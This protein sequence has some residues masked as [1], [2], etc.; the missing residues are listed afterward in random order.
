LRG[1]GGVVT[2]CRQGIG[3]ASM[4]AAAVL[5]EL[6]VEWSAA[7]GDRGGA[8]AV[9]PRHARAAGMGRAVRGGAAAAGVRDDGMGWV[10]SSGARG[11][12]GIGG[13][14]GIDTARRARR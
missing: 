6:G 11:R 4:M 2:H 7:G 5:I 1:G 14:D 10:A 12:D 9:D 3:R 8:G 13:L